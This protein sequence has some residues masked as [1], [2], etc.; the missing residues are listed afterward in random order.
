MELLYKLYRFSVRAVLTVG[1]LGR[2]S[3][4]CRHHTDNTTPL[5]CLGTTSASS[6]HSTSTIFAKTGI[7]LSVIM[8][9]CTLQIVVKLSVQIFQNHRRKASLLLVEFRPLKFSIL[10]QMNPVDIPLSSA[11]E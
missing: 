6:P 3:S 10:S 7:I 1:I 2:F 5:V 8:S 9:S 11:P 4:Q